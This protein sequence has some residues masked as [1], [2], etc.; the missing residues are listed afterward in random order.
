[1]TA[2]TQPAHGSAAIAGGGLTYQP[3]AGYCNDLGGTP[4]TFGYTLN[5]GSAATV[6]VTVQCVGVVP[7]VTGPVLV[8]GTPTSPAT[9]SIPATSTYPPF[10]GHGDCIHPGRP[11]P[12]RHPR[13]TTSWSA[14]ACATRS[15]AAPATTACSAS[16]E[17]TS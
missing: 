10:A 16:V 4:D 8:P 3:T 5:G 15:A 9:P 6:A 17:T 7:P 12:H 1:M 2:V 11:V 14:P 13:S